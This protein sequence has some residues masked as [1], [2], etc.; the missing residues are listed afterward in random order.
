M[1]SSDLEARLRVGFFQDKDIVTHRAIVPWNLRGFMLLNVC[2]SLCTD[3]WCYLRGFLCPGH[4]RTMLIN[5]I[6]LDP[7]EDV[8]P[9]IL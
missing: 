9:C 2:L 6:V 7:V 3:P 5:S 1:L 4:S 8:I